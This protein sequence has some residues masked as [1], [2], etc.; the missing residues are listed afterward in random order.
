VRGRKEEYKS[1]FSLSNYLIIP[2]YPW[3]N[4]IVREG[5]G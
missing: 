4:E 5:E 2:L 1:P 3:N